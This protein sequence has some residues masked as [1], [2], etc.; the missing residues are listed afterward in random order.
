MITIF[1][2]LN[3]DHQEFIALSISQLLADQLNRNVEIEQVIAI[4][5]EEEV[6]VEIAEDGSFMVQKNEKLEAAVKRITANF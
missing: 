1:S 4:F 6:E 5:T 3:T 2:D